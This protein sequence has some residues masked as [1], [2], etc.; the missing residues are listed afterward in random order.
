VKVARV[1]LQ[2]AV[3]FPGLGTP[4]YIVAG[5]GVELTEDERGIVVDIEAAAPG[6][7]LSLIPWANVRR[8]ALARPGGK[9][10]KP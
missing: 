7:G 10:R 3:Y 4:T 1:D 9:L 8:V 6:L 5:P 2:V